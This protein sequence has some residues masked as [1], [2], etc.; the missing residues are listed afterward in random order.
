MLVGK[1][2]LVNGNQAA[3]NEG[4]TLHGAVELPGAVEAL[5]VR[6]LGGNGETLAVIEL[7]AQAGGIVE[8]SWDGELDDGTRAPPGTYTISAAAD[9]GGEE[10]AMQTLSVANVNSVTL[11]SGADDVL[12]DLGAL[13]E[14]SLTDVR[15]IS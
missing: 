5:Q 3:L 13:G 11:G 1:Q 6:I 10:Q 4:G 2:V 8:F 12:L 9:L 7:G 14:I 15:R